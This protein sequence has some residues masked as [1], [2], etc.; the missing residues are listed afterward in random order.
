MSE[1][2]YKILESC[3]DSDDD[4]PKYKILELCPSLETE[5]NMRKL[6]GV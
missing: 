5:E 3:H 6:I 2:K 1:S 4:A